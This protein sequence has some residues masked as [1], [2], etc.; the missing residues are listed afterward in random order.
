[1]KIFFTSAS[2]LMHLL[3]FEILEIEDKY[4]SAYRIKIYA[5]CF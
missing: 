2:I 5:Y 4:Y 1:M 3:R